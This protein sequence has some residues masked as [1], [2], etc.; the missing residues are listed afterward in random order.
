MP[1]CLQM[2]PDG[3]PAP[4]LFGLEDMPP[5]TY[6]ISYDIFTRATEDNLPHGWNAYRGGSES[7]V[8]IYSYG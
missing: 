8:E 5:R 3:I 6:G 2:E 7:C 1:I 4:I